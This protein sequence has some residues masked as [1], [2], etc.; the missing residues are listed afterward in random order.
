MPTL[1]NS[2]ACPQFHVKTPMTDPIPLDRELATK[3]ADNL[4]LIC[5]GGIPSPEVAAALLQRLNTV[6]R[7]AD[8]KPVGC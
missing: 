5:R 2:A 3:L 7:N 6:I 8:R 1:A 4:I